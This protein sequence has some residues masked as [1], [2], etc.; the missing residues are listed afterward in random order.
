MSGSGEQSSLVVDMGRRPSQETA[1]QPEDDA[2]T[3][4]QYSI[5]YVHHTVHAD[6]VLIKVHPGS[7]AMPS[8]PSHATM[9]LT[10]RNPQTNRTEVKR[11][12]CTYEGCTRTYSTR[13]NLTTHLKKHTGEYN[14][15]CTDPSCGKMFMTSYRLKVH[16]R[17]HSKQRPYGC[18]ISGCQKTFRTLYRLNSHKRIHE[19]TTFN[20]SERNCLKFF[21]TLS[22][23]KKHKRTHTGEKPFRCPLA[24]CSRAFAL[25][26]HLRSHERTH[27]KPR[28]YSC[29][30][31]GCTRRFH[32]RSAQR[33]HAVRHHQGGL[34]PTPGA[35]VDW[36]T[37][38]FLEAA[39]G[40]A[41]AD[42]SVSGQLDA[43]AGA[44]HALEPPPPPREPEPGSPA[45]APLPPSP[46]REREGQGPATSVLLR[47]LTAVGD[48]PGLTGGRRH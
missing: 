21:T 43:A 9:T 15:V 35:A 10:S 14:F 8:E 46:V 12:H 1:R 11:L 45:T 38:I 13:G 30:L 42:G 34:G 44:E 27:A 37:P 26:H 16:L 41:S 6:K 3:A 19:G 39:D 32:T 33:L 17:V 4:P 36:G 28:P 2:A 20:C 47:A 23:L 7:Q 48:V 31:P 18:N 22:D 24:G 29:R 40:G 5:G 25:A